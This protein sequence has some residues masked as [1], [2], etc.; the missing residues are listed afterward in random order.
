[1]IGI[2]V[3]NFVALLIGLGLIMGIR[4]SGG[5]GVGIGDSRFLRYFFQMIAP[6][7]KT[8]VQLGSLQLVK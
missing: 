4:I 8:A 6:T 3:F 2:Q 5:D 1:V 7:E